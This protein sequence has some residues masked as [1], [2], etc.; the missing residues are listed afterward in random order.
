MSGKDIAVWLAA[1]VF[2]GCLG[3]AAVGEESVQMVERPDISKTNPHY[4]GSRAPLQPVFFLE[5]PAGSIEP[6]GWLREFLCRQRD[7]MTGHLG[8]ISA[9]LQKNDNAWLSPD[10]KGKWGWEEVP[11]W[12]RGYQELAYLLQEPAMMEEVQFWMEGVLKSQRQN[13]D[14]GPDQRFE[15]GSRDYWGNMIML[16]CLQS[17]YEYT[18]EQRVLELMR[19]YFQYQLKVPEKQFLTGYWQRMRG[20][21]NLFSVYWLYNRTAEPWLLE[22]AEKIHRCTADWRMENDLPNWHNVNIAQGFRE[23]AVYYLL[24]GSPKDLEFAYK[25]FW[26]VRKRYGQVP[27]GMFGGDENCRPGYDDPRQCI[28]TCGIVEQM[29]SDEMMMR[30]SGDPFWADHCEEAALNMYPAAVM[31]DFRAL[32]YLTAPNLAVSDRLD[33]HPGVDNSGP[34]LVMNPLSHRCCQHNHSH[35]WPNYARSLWYASPDGGACAALYAAC[36]VRLRVADGTEISIDEDTRYPFEEEIRLVVGVPRPTAFP[37]YLR[38]PAWCQ[39]ASLHLNGQPIRFQ[40][41]PGGG[42]IR[43]ERTWQ[44]KDRLTL[45][46]P[47]RLRVQR[48][49]ANHN[50]ATVYYGPLAFSLKIQERYVRADSAETALGDS[51][52][53]ESLDR[54]QWPAYEIFPDSPWNYGL[55]LEEDAPEKGFELLRKP[56]PADN[57]PFTLASVPLE[58]KTKARKIAHWTLDRFGLCAPLQDSPVRSAEP[59]ETV[60]LVPMGAARLRISAFPVI[61]DGPQAREWEPEKLPKP[62]LYAARAS[63]VHDDLSALCDQMIPSGSGDLTIP[64]FTWWDHCG[65]VEWVQYEFPSPKEIRKVE[66]YWFDDTGAGRCRIPASWRLLYKTPSGWKPVPYSGTYPVVR[67]GWSSVEFAPIQT[68][69]LRLEVRLQDGFS[70][71]ILE[72][73]ID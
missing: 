3:W 13:G 68:A 16:F 22:L 38:V 55:V 34:F 32:R 36:R 44:D 2:G 52:W 63:H 71:G 40:P 48:W 29:F 26:E 7:G 25:N 23:P 61:G 50:S 37:L 58:L 28:E 57:F 42:Y 65:T 15:D 41:R 20:G 54:T 46:L 45:T 12:L 33:H 59:T 51:K 56:W 8:Q 72:W 53:Q 4:I 21:E 39:D 66:V 43:L 31:P 60:T 62:P 30:I 67:D 10:G 19:R 69:A 9:W 11:Y 47:M 5:L 35:G 73:K 18:G 14:F 24:S 17:Y 49:T 27:G 6:R 1:A 64:R 70:G